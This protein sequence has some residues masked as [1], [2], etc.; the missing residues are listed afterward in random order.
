MYLSIFCGFGYPNNRWIYAISFIFSFITVIFLKDYKLD[1]KDLIYITTAVILYLGINAIFDVSIKL[2]LEIQFIFLLLYILIIYYKDKLNS[3]NKKYSLSNIILLFVFTLGII[4]TVKYRFDVEGDF[5]TTEYLNQNGLN[6]KLNTSYNIPDFNK[7]INYINESDN[8]FY[9][10][11]KSP[12]DYENVSL[13]KKFNSIGHYYSITPNIYNELNTDLNNPQ[14][15]ISFGNKEFDYRTKITTLLGVKYLINNDNNAV[16]YGYSLINDYKSSSKIYK[17]DYYLPFGTLYTNYI[18]EEEYEKLTPLQKEDSLLKSTVLNK[19]NISSSLTHNYNVKK[20]KEIN[21]ELIDE[22][23][24]ID[25]N[26]IEIKDIN[27][28]TFK[29]KLDEIINSEVYISFENIN[30][31][32][33]TKEEM[34]NLNVT[35]ETSLTDIA[36]LK[37]E[38]KWYQP[39]YGYRVNV[40]Y[41]NVLKD[42]EIK[43]YYTSAYYFPCPDI[44]INLGYYDNTKDE[45]E[46]S[47]S[48]IGKYTFDNIKIYAVPMDDYPNDIQNLKRSNF[49]VTEYKNGYLKGTTNATEDGILQLNTM[50]SKGWKVYVDGKEVETFTS[51]K[52]FLGINISKG[53]HEIYLKYHTP[54]L[55]EGLII[56]IGGIIIFIFIAYK[57][58][59][60]NN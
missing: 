21:Y 6:A 30:F 1:K 2:Y 5:Y 55:K 54:Y 12:Y 27:N 13:I 34:I 36:N 47:L 37:K 60:S 44:L 58:R 52:Y 41:N 8:D 28:N 18:T 24:I 20:F 29:L 23:G 17:N 33:Y 26:N 59:K 3:I 53:K 43:D 48:Q 38:Y 46:V 10:I 15:Y 31:K 19:E 32:P 49:N 16:P 11:S 25:K 51:N 45:V 7:A 4:T 9:K 22:N 35:E 40:K 56:S 57:K 42:R 39:S 50:Y 14:H